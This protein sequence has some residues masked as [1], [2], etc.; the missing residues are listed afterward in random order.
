M[1][2]MSYKAAAKHLKILADNNISCI[3]GY[4]SGNHLA[5]RYIMDEGIK[6]KMG[7]IAYASIYSTGSKYSKLTSADGRIFK[8]I[9]DKAYEPPGACFGDTALRKKGAEK[10]QKALNDCLPYHLF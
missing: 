8:G 6:Y 9:Y 10:M 4:R 5:W 2:N 3:P 7:T 1:P